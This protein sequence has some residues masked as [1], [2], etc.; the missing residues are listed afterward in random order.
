MDSIFTKIIKREIPGRFVYEDEKVVAFLTIA[1]IKKGH[2]LVVPKK[3]VD[4]WTDLEPEL[5]LHLNTVAYR[6]AQ[7]Q[8]ALFPC[9]R[10]GVIIAGM[11]VPHVHIHLVP[12]D[13]EQD[14][15][16][17]NADPN[18]DPKV[19]DQVAQALEKACSSL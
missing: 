10:V 5:W 7:H 9:E 1:P 18:P 13:Q 4:Q 11:E 2:T 8:K 3:Q 15:R 19:L 12:I 17:E 6:I 14:L 16:F